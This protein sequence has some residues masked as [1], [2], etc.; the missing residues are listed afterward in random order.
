M[1]K[2]KASM[3]AFLLWAINVSS[4][5]AEK[6]EM[7]AANEGDRW[8]FKANTKEML[9]STTDILNG[10]YEVVFL[11]GRFEVSQIVDGQKVGATAGVSEKLKR[12]IAVGQDDL[13][14]LNFPL[15]VSKKWTANYRHVSPGARRAQQRQATFQVENTQRIKVDAGEFQAF[16]IRGSGQTVDASVA[17]EWGYFYS[18]DTKSIVKFYYDSGVGVQSGK[19]EIELTKFHSS[20]R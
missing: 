19:E 1:K 8:E 12:M 16:R 13:Q 11:Q 18:P 5:G 7:S 9:T 2:H 17:R 3:I 10:N 15:S 4:Y 6:I 14:L 20:G